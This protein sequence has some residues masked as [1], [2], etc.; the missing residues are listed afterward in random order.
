MIKNSEK[1]KVIKMF[2]ISTGQYQFSETTTEKCLENLKMFIKD[3]LV[4]VLRLK[5]LLAFNHLIKEEIFTIFIFMIKED[6]I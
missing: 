4:L 1:L 5:I 2:G 6:K 3:H